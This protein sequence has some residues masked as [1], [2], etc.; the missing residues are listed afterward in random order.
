M[1]MTPTEAKAREVIK[2]IRMTMLS[3]TVGDNLARSCATELE[4]SLER[5]AR[6]AAEMQ[7]L[8]ER[9]SEAVERHC[10]G[11]P[12]GGPLA[13]FIIPAPDPLAEAD[14]MVATLQSEAKEGSATAQRAASIMATLI[15][16][17]RA[18]E[19]DTNA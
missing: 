1:T 16:A 9:F 18:Q 2:S 10:G 13:P 6:H 17:L 15:A 3:Y 5:E 11:K 19:K 4:K 8:K 7:E 14:K 12:L